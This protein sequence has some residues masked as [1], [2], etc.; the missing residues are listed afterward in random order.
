MSNHF[1]E[2]T[3]NGPQGLLPGQ[4][5]KKKSLIDNQ[6]VIDG[7]NFEYVKSIKIDIFDPLGRASVV[8]ENLRQVYR[9]LNNRGVGCAFSISS[10]QNKSYMDQINEL[11]LYVNDR[12]ALT[13]KDRF[14]LDR[15]LSDSELDVVADFFLRFLEVACYYKL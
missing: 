1:A 2:V 4:I 5:M 6:I 11:V 3:N 8:E 9:K 14:R 10:S 13:N 7:R 12:H 15:G